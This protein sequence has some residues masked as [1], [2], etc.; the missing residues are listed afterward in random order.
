MNQPLKVMHAILTTYREASAVVGPRPQS[1][2][3]GLA[4]RDVLNL[5]LLAEGDAA[6]DRIGNARPRRLG[7]VPLENGSRPLWFQREHDIERD[8]VGVNVEHPIGKHPE[9]ECVPRVGRVQPLRR[10]GSRATER[11]V[12]TRV[13]TVRLHA[14]PGVI[15][16]PEQAGMGSG[17]VVAF[18]VVVDVDLPVAGD[19]VDAPLAQPQPPFSQLAASARRPPRASIRVAVP[20]D[21][22]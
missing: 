5:R 22:G 21:R 17:D 20:S 10:R 12:L 6:G 19:V 8:V 11:R 9:I 13:E 4:Q 18:E 2:L 16:L 1:D 15:Q 7:D 3:H 14:V